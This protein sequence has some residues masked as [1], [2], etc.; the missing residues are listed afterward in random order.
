MSAAPA[1]AARG[2]GLADLDTERGVLGGLL[3]HPTMLPTAIADRVT[4]AT[5]AAPGHAAMFAAV[6]RLG[7]GPILDAPA[8]AVVD[9]LQRAGDL[10]LAG[11]PAG[12]VGLL[13]VALRPSLLPLAWERLTTLAAARAVQRVLREAQD[14]VERDPVGAAEVLGALRAA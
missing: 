11:G 7:S 6:V 4:P 8:S 5:F 9:E 12:V 3:L 14:R 2:A 10:P 1:P 13:I